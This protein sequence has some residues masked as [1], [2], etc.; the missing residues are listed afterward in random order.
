MLARS[1]DA[2]AR[3]AE[4]KKPSSGWL[5][6]RTSTP[7]G[8]R[9]REDPGR[10]RGTEG[11]PRVTKRVEPRHAI[12]INGWVVRPGNPATAAP[13]PEQR[14]RQQDR[15]AGA[16]RRARGAAGGLLHGHQGGRREV[17]T[18]AATVRGRRRFGSGNRS[19]ERAAFSLA[20]RATLAIERGAWAE[21]EALAE[22]ADSVMR[23]SHMQEYPPNWST[24]RWPASRSIGATSHG[25]AGSS[26]RPSVFVRD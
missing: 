20:E 2:F 1:A 3:S 7:T 25:P 8:C 5:C 17:R 4:A 21:A 13:F 16:R 23:R 9:N 6:S 19:V 22:Q 11:S 12:V 18:P 10:G 26:P 14:H 15:R 24:S